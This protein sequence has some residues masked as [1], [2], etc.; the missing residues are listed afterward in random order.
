MYAAHFNLN[1]L[2]FEESSDP[3]F[4]WL[5]KKHLKALSAFKDAV[6]NKKDF[7]LFSG[8]A[9]TGKTALIER[10]LAEI[11]SNK[12]VA[13]VSDPDLDKLNFFNYLSKEFKMDTI[14]ETQ[15]DFFVHFKKFLLDAYQMRTRV[16]LIIDEAHKINQ[17]ILEQILLFSNIEKGDRKL[18]DIIIAGWH[19]FSNQLPQKHHKAFGQKVAF[20]FH[21][22]P[23]SENET[24]KLILHRLRVAGSKT[25]IFSSGAFSEIYRFSAG[26]PRL[27]VNICNLAMFTGYVREKDHIDKDLIIECARKLN[28]T[29]NEVE[30]DVENIEYFYIDKKDEV[31]GP[32]K[33]YEEVEKSLKGDSLNKKTPKLRKALKQ[34]LLA[35]L[36]VFFGYLLH[37]PINFWLLPGKKL[38]RLQ[39]TDRVLKE[40]PA[41]SFTETRQDRFEENIPLQANGIKESGASS[42]KEAEAFDAAESAIPAPLASKQLALPT[43]EVKTSGQS[44]VKK[45]AETSRPPSGLA[46]VQKSLNL[47]N[48]ETVVELHNSDSELG[49]IPKERNKTQSD[50]ASRKPETAEGENAKPKGKA[51]SLSPTTSRKPEISEVKSEGADRKPKP[52]SSAQAQ[53]TVL[54]KPVQQDLVS[55]SKLEPT[56]KIEAKSQKTMLEK[57]VQQ[58][59]VPESKLEPTSK[60]EAKSPSEIARLEPKTLDSNTD[61]LFALEERLQS[62]L[63]D[64]C[65]TYAAKDLDQFTTFFTSD[66]K[67]NGKPV[68]DLWS[69]YRRNFDSIDLINYR[70]EL[71]EY[72]YDGKL[73]TVKIEGKFF[74]RWLPRGASWRENSGKIYM[75]L[76]GHGTSYQV[77][78]LDYFGEGRKRTQ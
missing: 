19:E 39:E 51:K 9:G 31:D 78:R 27:V 30:Q 29:R 70:I 72:S 62:F 56:S 8:D 38:P 5:G 58:D 77:D 13:S 32:G 17:E 73:E 48:K 20:T 42:K 23:L 15:K 57:P 69:K 44:P 16:I 66:A 60:I 25:K 53:K 4:I 35:I 55:E 76:K 24:S 65:R 33:I 21:L 28:I 74:L 3:K 67:E 41:K 64:Y 47:A 50:I 75:V 52:A 2:P 37:A 26:Y 63:Q 14:F 18:I 59:L 45:V 54:E 68:S 40:D 43:P 36:L 49:S 1:Q 7:F 34:A 11:D 22:E 10:F 46:E 71:Q 12:I 6:H 61:R